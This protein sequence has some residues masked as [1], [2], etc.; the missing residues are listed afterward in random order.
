ME[1]LPST[2][3]KLFAQRSSWLRDLSVQMKSKEGS[4]E[5]CFLL[6]LKNRDKNFIKHCCARWL[7]W[8]RVSA[9]VKQKPWGRHRS[10][11]SSEEAQSVTKSGGMVHKRN[12]KISSVGDANSVQSR[13]PKVRK[14]N[15]ERKWGRGNGRQSRWLDEVSWTLQATPRKA[16]LIKGK[17]APN[18]R[19][20]CLPLLIVLFFCLWVANIHLG[21][22]RS[23]RRRI[24]FF[25]LFAKCPGAAPRSFLRIQGRLMFQMRSNYSSWSP[26]VQEA[27]QIVNWLRYLSFFS[28]GFLHHSASS[29]TSWGIFTVQP[30][31]HI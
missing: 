23:D 27:P 13:S 18:S 11:E 7:L 9:Y 2:V 4:R 19:P 5:I 26:T 15:S 16:V 28:W 25:S 21:P 3:N 30:A 6:T 31:L 24:L 8:W 17:K 29:A 20:V 22:F 10:S 1:V 12:L 14:V